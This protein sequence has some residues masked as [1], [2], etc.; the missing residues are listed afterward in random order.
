MKVNKSLND[1]REC[2]TISSAICS[3]LVGKTEE[4][5]TEFWHD[6]E[7]ILVF[8]GIASQN[9][10]RP[11]SVMTAWEWMGWISAHTRH[12]VT[13]TCPNFKSHQERKRRWSFIFS[14]NCLFCRA[15]EP[16][17]LRNFDCN[18]HFLVLALFAWPFSTF[19]IYFTART[20]NSWFSP[21]I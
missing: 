12:L 4:R 15:R 20:C 5:E 9:S 7:N 3:V 13:S 21:R 1:Q 8:V 18:Y 2:R 16:Y 19:D 17:A 10:N 6:K 14:N 11:R